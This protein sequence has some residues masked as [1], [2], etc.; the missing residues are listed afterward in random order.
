MRLREQVARHFVHT[1]R[2]H[3]RALA[4]G[5]TDISMPTVLGKFELP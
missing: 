4:G 3:A 5:D 1:Q 2:S